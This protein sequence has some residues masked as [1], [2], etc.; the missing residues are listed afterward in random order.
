MQ[1]THHPASLVEGNAAGS[2]SG[3]R[4]SGILGA[5]IIRIQLPNVAQQP[6]QLVTSICITLGWSGINP[7]ESSPVSPLTLT[8]QQVPTRSRNPSVNRGACSLDTGTV[9]IFVTRAWTV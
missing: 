7:I 8:P 9:H 5:G 1:S 6:F 2:N 4:H 3:R